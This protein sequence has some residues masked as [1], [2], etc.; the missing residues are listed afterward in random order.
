M[1]ENL[2][3]STPILTEAPWSEDITDYDRAH[4]TTY[5]RILDA[6]TDKASPDE[7]A[8]LIL[9]IDPTKEPDRAR[10]AVDSHIKRARWLSEHGRLL[11]AQPTPRR[12]S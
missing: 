5:L 6:L 1:P 4:L 8:R 7:M 9:G 2:P 10:A 12:K 3:P 11:A